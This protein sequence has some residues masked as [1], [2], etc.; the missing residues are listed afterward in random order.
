MTRLPTGLLT[1]EQLA[2]HIKV[3][4]AKARTAQSELAHARRLLKKRKK[5]KRNEHPE[6]RTNCD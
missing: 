4:D 1:D 3:L 5:E 6:H 2:A